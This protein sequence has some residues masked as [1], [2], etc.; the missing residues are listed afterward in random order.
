MTKFSSSF[1][2][3]IKIDHFDIRYRAEKFRVMY[4]KFTDINA[5]SFSMLLHELTNILK[6]K[7]EMTWR[8]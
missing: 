7:S 1:D 3:D 6:Q 4:M 8:E 2:I 5:I